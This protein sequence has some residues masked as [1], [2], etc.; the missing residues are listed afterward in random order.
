MDQWA[1]GDKWV[2]APLP[3]GTSS[4]GTAVRS[5]S[6][7]QSQNPTPSKRSVQSHDILYVESQDIPYT[8]AR[9]LG[10]ATR[11]GGIGGAH[12]LSYGSDSNLRARIERKLPIKS[13]RP[14]RSGKMLVVLKCTFIENCTKIANQLSVKDT[15]MAK[16]IYAVIT[17]D[18]VGSRQLQH[19]RK[20]RDQKLAPIS[21]RHMKEEL[22]ISDYAVTAWDEFQAILRKPEYMSQVIFDLRRHFYPIEL[23]VAVGIGEVS[24]PYKKPVNVFAGGPAFERARAAADELKKRT[25]KSRYLTQIRSD[26]VVFDTV[27]NTMYH[28]HDTLVQNIT[29]KQWETINAFVETQSQELT[30]KKLKLDSSTVSRNLKRGHFWEIDETMRA[31]EMFVKAHFL[32]VQKR[33]H[34]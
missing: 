32:G 18:I 6:Q 20:V 29:R 22:I 28:L 31:V 10:R 21:L 9:A 2:G 1:S 8:P 34:S 4:E 15:E 11:R 33:T 12:Q 7:A 24:E 14:E 26:N 25:S 5:T 16:K 3:P 30:A 13:A 17:A 27:S 23:W 19:F